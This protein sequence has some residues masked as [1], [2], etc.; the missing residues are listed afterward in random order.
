MWAAFLCTILFSGSVICG[1]RSARQVGATEA[2]FWRLSVAALILGVWA[3]AAGQGTSSLGL[4]WFVLSGAIG[5]GI[6]DTAFFQALPKLGSRL[7]LLLIECL[8]PPF[9]VLVEWL[10]LGTRLTAW[11]FLC[12]AVILAG[13]ALA[14]AP[15]E[16]R[17]LTRRELATG[18]GFCVV[19]ALAT[20]CG[21][22]VSRKGYAEVADARLAVDA[23]TVAF[24]RVLGGLPPAA[25]VLLFAKRHVLKLQANAP[26][27]IP[28]AVSMNKWRGIWPWI[29]LNGLLGQTLGVSCM[30][31][32]LETTPTG[33][34]LAI[35]A[36]TPIVVIPLAW[37]FEGERPTLKSLIG[38]GVAVAG[39]VALVI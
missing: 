7:T 4:G 30:Q 34:V 14:V 37:A 16:S 38:G 2:N 21:A 8:Q 20:A 25:A 6:G 17:K 33:I 18:V 9:G 12:G 23:G 28:S 32:A 24:Q 22:V 29:L 35:I 1:H 19:A 36:I 39:A 26:P 31:K 15:H 5:I 11:Q 3:W 10:W 27:G 13:V